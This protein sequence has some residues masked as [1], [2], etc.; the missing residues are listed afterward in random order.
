MAFAEAM[1]VYPSPVVVARRLLED[2]NFADG[3]M[4]P[5]GSIVNFNLFALHRRSDTWDN[6]NDFDLTRWERSNEWY[7]PDSWLSSSLYPTLQ[8]TSFRYAPF[9][10][11]PRSCA[12]ASFAALEG[13]TVLAILLRKYDFT[14]EMLPSDVRLQ[15][16]VFSLETQN[17]IMMRAHPQDLAILASA[18]AFLSSSSYVVS[19]HFVT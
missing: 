13:V 19:F 1:R 7:S 17:G 12:G 15:Q 3:R 18:S 14:F 9:G 11:G 16:T 4:I 2:V 5:S 6:P 8:S 10:A